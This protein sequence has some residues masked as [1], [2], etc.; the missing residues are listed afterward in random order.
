MRKISALEALFAWA[1]RLSAEKEYLLHLQWRG[2]SRSLS[3]PVSPYLIR[4][5]VGVA[6]FLFVGAVSL[7]WETGRWALQE[8]RYHLAAGKHQLHLADLRDIQADLKTIESSLDRAFHQEQRMRALYGISYP[9]TS[10][11]AFGVG[12]RSQPDA[13]PRALSQ[14]LQEALFH[15]QLK[16]R[17]LRGKIDH[18][19]QNFQQIKEF[20]DYRHNLWDHT[21]TVTPATGNWSSGFGYR[22]HPV[23]G[24]Y[25]LHSGLD[26]AGSK[27]TPVH[28]TADGLVTTAQ[29]A[30]G[31]G[32]L[33]VVN[34][35]NGYQT[36]YG[37]FSRVMVKKG[38][39]VK[40]FELLGYMGR[41]GVAT[42]VHVHY[43]VLRD[44]I[45]L[46][47][48]RYILPSGLVVD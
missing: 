25:L 27:W 40:R 48:Q 42:G 5:I 30:L 10:P 35:D 36:K 7:T 46:N 17:Q 31:Y 28:A 34:H 44:G 19:L 29:P 45:H 6:A 39:L 14:G 47:P 2:Q 18:T 11:D 8:F 33:V 13:A 21:P 12:G 32:N 16:D 4:I 22:M 24:R 1:F 9:G 41:T 23:S 3:R 15:A 37:H 20:M 43:E 26:I 38:Q